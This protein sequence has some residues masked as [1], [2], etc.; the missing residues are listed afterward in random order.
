MGFLGAGGGGDPYIGR[1]MLE[2]VMAAGGRVEIVDLCD[3]GDGDFVIPTAMMGA[4]TCLIEKIP[5]GDESSLSLR[6]LEAHLGRKAT[7]TMP[8][9]AGGVNSTIPLLV[10]ARLGLPVIDADGMGRAFPNL[11]QVTFHVHGVSGTPMAITNEHGDTAIV[12]THDNFMLEWI[13]RGITIRMGGSAHTAE[14][15]M[16]GA[17]VRRTAVAG[18]LGFC[19]AI[20]SAI[21]EARERHTDPFDSI[22]GALRATPYQRGKVLWSGKVVEVYRRTTAGFARGRVLVQDT[23]GS[24]EVLEV[25]FQN[26][27][28]VARVGA[29]IL[30]IVPDLVCI[31]DQDTAEPITTEALRYGQRVR[32][33]GVATPPIMRTPEALS[34]FGPRAF[35]LD[36]DFVPLEASGP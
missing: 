26:E 22:L 15:P 7:C 35:G 30:S 8:I 31:L 3:V 1:L 32:V 14:F 5:R 36:A 6:R 21:R 25:L 13:A 18:T 33:L 34:V 19:L 16:D 24:R 27:N 9:E 17:T 28:L 10:G 23:E 12:T 29:R 2:R 20:G 4:P 11:Y